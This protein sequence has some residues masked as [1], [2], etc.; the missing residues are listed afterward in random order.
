MTSVL[1]NTGKGGAP[2]VRSA[3]KASP[4]LA[5]YFVAILPALT[6]GILA[7]GLPA[8]YNVVLSVLAA[9][10]AEAVSSFILRKKR[11]GGFF[12]AA[13]TGALVP[14]CLPVNVG[15]A[16]PAAASFVAVLVIRRLLGEIVIKGYRISDLVEPVALAWC[17]IRLAVGE[18]GIYFEAFAENGAKIKETSLQVLRTGELPSMTLM[19]LFLGKCAGAVGEISALL[20]ALG[21]VYLILRKIVSWRV[22]VAFLAAAAL[23]VLVYPRGVDRVSIMAYQMLSGGL[24]LGAFFVAALPGASPVTDNG[25]LIYGAG[26]GILTVIFRYFGLFAEGVPFAVL[27]MNLL[28]PLIDSLTLP[29]PVGMKKTRNNKKK[30]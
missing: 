12:L 30:K 10:A 21:G 3:D 7:Y 5:E 19:D 27:V 14:M 17:V 22:P 9:L 23:T 28:S 26:C 4:I 16:I 2:Y 25:K 29:R 6:W 15:A 1:R 13:I 11:P 24:F 18:S 8:A 20:I